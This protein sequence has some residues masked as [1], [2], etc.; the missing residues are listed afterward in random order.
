MFDLDTKISTILSA[1]PELRD[2]LPAFHPA[3][4]K[5][6]H[7]VLGRVMPRL[8]NVRDAAKV[9]GVDPQALLEVINLPG[10]PQV[11]PA[12][13]PRPAEPTPPWLET[14]PRVVLDLRPSLAEG[15]EPFALIIK[16]SRELPP[17][18][19]LELLTP[20]EPAPLRSFL[21]ARGWESAC[22]LGEDAH[23]TF[24]LRMEDAPDQL[25]GPP[26][27]EPVVV[28]G[29][30]ELDVR[31]L[32]AP[33]PLRAVLS[34]VDSSPEALR[35]R[36]RRLPS[37]LFPKLEARGRSFSVQEEADDVWIRIDET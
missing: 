21:G 29:V 16:A 13:T 35:V 5:L 33:E 30:R 19:A 15:R 6:K 24:F 17:G 1:R 20:F 23:H 32:E 9:A 3:F 8:V 18:H 25:P 4:E 10:P 34:A 14:T 11:S 37:L 7:P 2:T 27:A 31:N 12:P 36:H 26:L 28:N 22:V